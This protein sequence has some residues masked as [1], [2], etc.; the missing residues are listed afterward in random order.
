MTSLSY[1]TP[2]YA[3]PTNILILSSDTGGGHRSAA[4]AL[5]ES[6]LS[7]PGGR[8]ILVEV[9]RVLEEATWLTGRLAD[10]Y[11]HLL[12]HRQDWMKYYYDLIQYL[13]PNES[14]LI[15]QAALGYGTRVMERFCPNVIVSVHP[16]TQ[17]FFAYV[18]KRLG[19]LGKIPLLTVVTDPCAGFW[20]GW[21][22]PAVDRY[23]V[24]SLDAKLQLE[25]YGVEAHRIQVSGM[26]VHRRFKPV[27][28]EEQ[29][30]LRQ[31]MG[32]DADKFTLFMNAGWIGG[33]NI[34]KIYE[35]LL[36]QTPPSCQDRLQL[37]FLAGQNPALVQQAQDLAAVSTLN[38]QV[39]DYTH[40]I[41]RLMNAADVMVSKLGGLTTFEALASGLPILADTITP[42]MPQEART[43]HY[44]QETGAG[45]LLGKPGDV[46]SVVQSLLTSPER[47]RGLKS[48]AG[49]YAHHGASDRIVQSILQGIT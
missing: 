10:L 47:L 2:A 6:F 18:L 45:I 30:M 44:L 46:V 19:L 3:A 12:R 35:A 39:M 34:P 15:F 40:E 21:A 29:A 26:P 9:A 5:E 37:V 41:H 36:T 24:A 33:G 16:M 49:G 14:R 43:A 38:V 25:A 1:P 48:A 28:V 20:K 17:H 13:R 22:C 8:R 32:L 4:S 42:P 27:G 7:I 31:Q 23:Y 11:N